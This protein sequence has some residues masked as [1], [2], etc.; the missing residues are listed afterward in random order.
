M[1]NIN[2]LPKDMQKTKDVRRIAILVA[3]VQ[4]AVF[5]AVIAL[6]AL[7]SALNSKNEKEA[8]LLGR[9]LLQAEAMLPAREA[10]AAIPPYGFLPR[11]TLG[12]AVTVPCG[13]LITA[14]RFSHG[15]FSLAAMTDCVANIQ[16]HMEALGELFLDI[17]L[18]RLAALA[19]GSYVYELSLRAR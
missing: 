3:A 1:T 17:R 19:C 5:L 11:A 9:Q 2:L 14:I 4:A 18:A 13:V 7:F 8:A 12:N 10:S 6:A 15:E 16:A